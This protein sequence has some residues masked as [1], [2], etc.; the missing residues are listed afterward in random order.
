MMTRS[1][2]FVP[3]KGRANKKGACTWKMLVLADVALTLVVE[4]NEHAEYAKAV[5]AFC[6]ENTKHPGLVSFAVLEKSDQGIGYARQCILREFASQDPSVWSWMLDDDLQLFARC[7]EMP[8]PD[9]DAG[10]VVVKKDD[11]FQPA[12]FFAEVE[13]RL[14]KSVLKQFP[15]VVMAGTNTFRWVSIPKRSN[16]SLNLA[17]NQCFCFCPGR[18]PDHVMFRLPI[19][20]DK[21]FALQV[22][23]EGGMTCSF[24]DL[25]FKAPG[26]GESGRGGMS[27]FY[28]DEAKI[29][30]GN[31][32]FLEYWPQVAFDK[33][34]VFGEG[35][36]TRRIKG[37]DVEWKLIQPILSPAAFD[38][39]DYDAKIRR[40]LPRPQDTL[41]LRPRKD[42]TERRFANYYRCTTPSSSS[43][44]HHEVAE[45]LHVAKKKK[46]LEQQ[47]DDGDVGAST[48]K[49]KR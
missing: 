1:N 45:P 39:A 48:A 31:K 11:K 44:H 32:I 38:E 5:M 13:G 42:G 12:A 43:P 15:R 29:A 3:T 10:D 8:V 18:I 6:R 47:G 2:I 40:Y 27:D 24:R 9:D 28:R 33:D 35:T 14:L 37:V 20:E 49:K 46:R 16:F 25:A 26:M 30:S 41:E 23:R 34:E 21:D 22:I 4:P 36:D 19:C 7:I 17:C